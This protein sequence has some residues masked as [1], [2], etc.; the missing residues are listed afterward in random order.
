MEGK[1]QYWITKERAKADGQPPVEAEP[2]VDPSTFH[3]PSPSYWPIWIATGT[4]LIAGGILSHYAMSFVGGVIALLG[5]IGWSNEPPA[6]PSEHHG[7]S[8]THQ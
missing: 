7:A 8:G 3:M 1:D 2:H 6:A 4:A 5:I